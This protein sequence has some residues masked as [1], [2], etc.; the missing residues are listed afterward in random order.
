[1]ESIKELQEQYIQS[2]NEMEKQGYIIAKDH[3]GSSFSLEK[4][5]GF[6]EW[7]KKQNITNDTS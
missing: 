5:I 4:S 3:L 6:K 7:L 1:M 2:M